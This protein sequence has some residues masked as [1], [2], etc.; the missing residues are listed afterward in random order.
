MCQKSAVSSKVLCHQ[1]C[2]VIVLKK[3]KIS[4]V[5]LQIVFSAMWLAERIFSRES[6]QCR[7]SLG[8][9]LHRC[10]NVWCIY[11]Y[12]SRPQQGV[13]RCTALNATVWSEHVTELISTR[14]YLQY[15]PGAYEQQSCIH[16]KWKLIL[17]FVD[18][19]FIH[20]AE[21]CQYPLSLS[22]PWKSLFCQVGAL[23][24]AS[25]VFQWSVRT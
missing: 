25:T 11:V 23:L 5:G 24:Y 8:M 2:C 20:A 3:P 13:Q 15:T 12:E 19:V 1:K 18:R 10:R 6:N 16:L 4:S 9:R 22:G 7:W 14:K 17:F 21:S